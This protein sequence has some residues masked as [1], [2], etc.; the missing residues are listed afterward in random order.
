MLRRI[1]VTIY[2]RIVELGQ[3]ED[4]KCRIDRSL[5]RS[6]FIFYLKTCIYEDMKQGILTQEEYG[7]EREKYALQIRDLE[8]EEKIFERDLDDFEQLLNR[9][10]RWMEAFLSFRNTELFTREMAAELLEKV[11]LYEN[12][13][14]HIKFRFR[15]EYEYLISQLK[16]MDQ[17]RENYDGIIC[18]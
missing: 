10:N 13:R 12:K 14:V 16:E 4:G 17:G 5:L 9:K 11:E 6:V 7:I 18:G 1:A 15:D 2:K 3:N 8:K